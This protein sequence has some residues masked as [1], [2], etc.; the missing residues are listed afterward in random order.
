MKS[1]SGLILLVIGLLVILCCCVVVSIIGISG[2]LVAG[3]S[4]YEQPE[5][6]EVNY[7]FLSQPDTRTNRDNEVG[8]SRTRSI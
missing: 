7:S 5:I 8:S 2:I 4:V 1:T 3:N 6:I